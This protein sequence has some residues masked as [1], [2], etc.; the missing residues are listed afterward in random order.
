[1]T[2][3]FVLRHFGLRDVTGGRQVRCYGSGSSELGQ[4]DAQIVS[5]VRLVYAVCEGRHLP[6]CKA[7]AGAAICSAV[8]SFR[9]IL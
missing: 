4:K 3:C 1:M 5:A 6:D 8:F 7:L 2:C 9:N